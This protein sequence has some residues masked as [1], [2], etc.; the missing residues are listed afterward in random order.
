MGKDPETQ[1]VNKDHVSE[2][3]LMCLRLKNI[4][5]V[6]DIIYVPNEEIEVGIGGE[7]IANNLHPGGNVAIPIT[8]YEL[9]WL[10]LVEKGVHV[11]DKS[12]TYSNGNEWTQGY[13]VVEG[14]WYEQ[15]QVKS[16]SYFL[17]NDQPL[18]FV[19]SHLILASK[20]FLPSTSHMA[21]GSYA[22]YELKD[23]VTKIILKA[24]KAFKLLD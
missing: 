19:F 20:K 8:T 15:L 12:F 24:F 5:E 10:M 21:K 17:R 3:I 22:T 13:M 1:C 23:D 4:L 9:F 16:H 14:Y 2:W 7:W 6:R 18:A 11:V